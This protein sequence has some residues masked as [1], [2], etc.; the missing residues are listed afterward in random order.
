M[1]LRA[2]IVILMLLGL[3]GGCHQASELGAATNSF[4]R[5][6]LNVD[7][8]ENPIDD[9]YKASL[10]AM[11]D[12]DLQVM[13]KEFSPLESRIIARNSKDE[14]VQV[15]VWRVT[16]GTSKLKIRIGLVGNETQSLAIYDQIQENL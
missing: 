16:E 15:W 14:K 3:A 4:V 11:N 7:T 12:L 2:M 5:G 6:D 13:S 1:K 9:V 8:I 10:D